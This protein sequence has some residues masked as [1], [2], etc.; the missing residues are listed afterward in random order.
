VLNEHSDIKFLIVGDGPYAP[1][2]RNLVKSM[3]LE[4]SFIFTGWVPYEDMPDF[5]NISR[6]NIVPIPDAP[7]TQGVLTL[8]LF[9]AMACGTPTIISDLPGVREHIID[10][11]TACLARPESRESLSSAINMLVSD[12]KLY[13]KIKENGL[14]MMPH[15]DWR[16]I[17]KD[18]ADA[19]L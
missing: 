14:K 17:A 6:I 18:M 9:E 8:K 2:L 5:M 10:K 3:G 7:C 12:K 11:K 13:N 4:K 19:I 15:Y 1:V 16:E